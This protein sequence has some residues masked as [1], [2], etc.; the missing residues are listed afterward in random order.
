MPQLTSDGSLTSELQS[1]TGSS[2]QGTSNTAGGEVNKAKLEGSVVCTEVFDEHS[3]PTE[4]GEYR[5]KN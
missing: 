5:Y 1:S 4:D 2:D 3:S